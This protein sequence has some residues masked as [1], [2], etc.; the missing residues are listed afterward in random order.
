MSFYLLFPCSSSN[1]S[2]SPKALCHLPVSAMYLNNALSVFGVV[3]SF[4]MLMSRPPVLFHNVCLAALCAGQCNIKCCT[5]SSV[6]WQSGHTGESIF[7][8]P[9][10]CLANGVCPVLSCDNM[11]ASFLGNGIMSLR[12]LSGWDLR[13]SLLHLIIALGR[14]PFLLHPFLKFL[15]KRLYH[16]RF[17]VQ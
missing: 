5:V 2:S 16:R 3:S 1:S 10:K 4:V 7:P 6:C 12:Y 11:L 8:I 14:R 17:A 9:T 13:I 15:P